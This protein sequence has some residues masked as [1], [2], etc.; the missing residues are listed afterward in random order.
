MGNDDGAVKARPPLVDGP[1]GR[2][3]SCAGIGSK[4]IR[5]LCERRNA[6]VRTRTPALP[7]GPRPCDGA[8]MLDS[9]KSFFGRHATPPPGAEPK[10]A[11]AAAGATTARPLHVAACALLLELAHADNEFSETERAHVEEAIVRHFDLPVETARELVTLADAE[12]RQATDLFQFTSLINA[13]YDE[14]QRTV[15]AEVLWRLVYADGQ[16]SQ[17]EDYLMRKLANLLDLRPGFLAEA[18][19]RAR[20]PAAG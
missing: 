17:H 4:S 5:V 16:L 7:A 3:G 8:A 6:K 12:R 13:S 14:A 9:I 1:P 11:A 18:R 2:T 15:L 20:G 10:D 19:A